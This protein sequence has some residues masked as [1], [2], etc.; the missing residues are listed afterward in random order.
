MQQSFQKNQELSI[1][2][3]ITQT[4]VQAKISP[5]SF[6]RNAAT[7]L[8]IGLCFGFIAFAMGWYYLGINKTTRHV[9]IQSN[10]LLLDTVPSTTPKQSIDN[11]L[12]LLSSRYLS[13][14]YKIYENQRL[15]YMFEHPRGSSVYDCPD[16]PC[17]S[18]DQYTIRI[19]ALRMYGKLEIESDD[20]YCSAGGPTGSTYC[21][22][23]VAE[24]FTNKYQ[25][26]GYKVVR[27][28]VNE[29]YNS[30]TQASDREE[31]SDRAYVFRIN[32]SEYKS[33]L[34]TADNPSP[35]NLEQLDAIAQS[36]K[37]SGNV[38]KNTLLE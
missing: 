13:S 7:L 34:F 21:L 20:L 3:P 18:I 14:D 8:V 29:T 15:G 35:E 4:S 17:A 38:N 32:N 9:Q 10:R 16:I 22:D 5:P 33:V 31:L 12:I 28:R 30:V 19:E 26:N 24:P 1:Q 27:T 2:K 6:L 25:A 37:L 23:P 11:P 36:F